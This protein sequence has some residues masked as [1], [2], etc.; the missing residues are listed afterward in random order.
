MVQGGGGGVGAQIHSRS[1]I[2]T[3]GSEVHTEEGGQAGWVGVTAK[4]IKWWGIE[5]IR[6]AYYLML[7]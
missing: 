2:S 1:E 5:G 3:V 6:K 7:A 4:R